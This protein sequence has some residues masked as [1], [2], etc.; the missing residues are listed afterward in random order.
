MST[1]DDC[2]FCRIRDKEIPGDFVFEDDSVFAIRDIHPRAPVHI[3]II[4]KEHISTVG[5]LS[6]EQLPIM[7]HLTGVANKVARE[8]GVA[9]TGYR[10]AVNKG[11]AANMTIWHLHMQL[12]GGRQLGEEG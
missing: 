12:L 9:E 1:S 6:E 8:Q 2:I 7:G 10:L 11:P 5:D 3:L 4:P